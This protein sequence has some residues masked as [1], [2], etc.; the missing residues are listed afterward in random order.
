MNRFPM[1]CRCCVT[2]SGLPVILAAA[3]LY[4]IGIPSRFPCWRNG[5]TNQNS[6]QILSMSSQGQRRTAPPMNSQRNIRAG[7]AARLREKL[8]MSM[9]CFI[10]LVHLLPLQNFP[11]MGAIRKHVT[12]H[13]FICGDRNFTSPCGLSWWNMKQSRSSW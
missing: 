2:A 1:W 9:N 3:C 5:R 10:R 13:G 6:T 4:W 12:S 8:S 11:C 7:D